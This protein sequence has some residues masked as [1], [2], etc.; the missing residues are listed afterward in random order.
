MRSILRSALAGGAL[1]LAAGGTA[2]AAGTV[3]PMERSWPTDGFFGK[4]DRAGLQRGFQVYMNV[5]H[6][7]HGLKYVAFRSLSDL[8][9]NEDQIKAIAAEYTVTDGPNDE[10]DMFE[11]PA[12]PS[13]RIPSPFAND[14][15]ARAAN[16]G[17]LPP[18]LSLIVKARED[19]ENY[20]FSLLNGFEEPPADVHVPDGMYYNHYFPG[21]LIGMPP[22]LSDDAITYEDGTP[23]TVPNMASDVV[24]FLT[25][26]AEPKLEARKGTGLA[27]VLFS[28][29]FIGIFYAYKRRIWADV[30]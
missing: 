19:G 28:L 10:G 17:A 6:A 5:C 4:F 12:R 3:P 30:H 27:V 24:Q 15:A 14:Q 13:D 22:P 21:H 23:A 25:W 1:L 18:D 7:C 16:G 9:Y 20:V 11:R 2:F 8:G 26:A 29:V